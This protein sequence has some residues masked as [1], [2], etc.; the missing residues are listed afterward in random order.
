MLSRD[1]LGDVIFNVLAPSRRLVIRQ[2][3][4]AL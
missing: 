4:A 3:A 1:L 2:C